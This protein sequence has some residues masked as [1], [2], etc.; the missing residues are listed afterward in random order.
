MKWIPIARPAPEFV[1]SAHDLSPKETE[2]L[3]A[4]IDNPKTNMEKCNF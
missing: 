1:I 2:E 3:D 4:R